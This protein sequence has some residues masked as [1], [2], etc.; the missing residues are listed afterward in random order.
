MFFVYLFVEGFF[1]VIQFVVDVVEN[2]LYW[3]S[4]D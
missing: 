1:K 2:D 3:F 4:F